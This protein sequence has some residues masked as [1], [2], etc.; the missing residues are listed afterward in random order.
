[1][2]KFLKWFSISI[3]ILLVLLIIAPFLFKG[4]IIS[5]IKEETNQNLNAKVD[6]SDVS[7]SLIRNFPNVSVGLEN[8][9]VINLQPFEGDTLVYAKKLNVVLDLMSVISGDQMIIRS[10]SLNDPVL[11]FLVNKDGIPNWDIAKKEAAPSESAQPSSF[12]ASLKKY[13]V[14][15]AKILYNDET[16]PFMLNLEGVDHSGSGDFT[17]DLFTLSTLSKVKRGDME[18]AGIRYISK[19]IAE[20]QADLEMDMKNLK[21]TFKQ[22]KVALNDLN[23]GVDGW[24]AMPDTNIDMDLKFAAAQSDF[25]NFISMVPA[26]YSE[27]FKDVKSSG[28]MALNGYIK[29]RYNAVSMPGFG[30]DLDI[31]NGMFKYPSLPA[32][33][34]NVFVNLKVD[35]PDGIPDHTFINLSRFHMEMNGDPFDAKLVLKTPVSD[36]DLDAFLKG[37]VDLSGIS[38]LVPLEKGTS[39]NGVIT[40][41]LTAKG[42]MSSIEKKQYNEF[43]AAGN[44]NLTGM[45]YASSEMKTPVNIQELSLSF[46][47]QCVALNAFNAKVGKSDF[48]ATGTIDNLLGFYLK[49]EMLKGAFNLNSGKIDLNEFMNGSGQAS[50]ASKD[51]AAMAVLDIPQNIDF[52]LNAMIGQLFYQNVIINNMKGELLVKDK[53]IRMKGVNMQLMDGSVTMDGSYSSANLKNPSFDFDMNIKDFD[54]QRTSLTFESVQKM[55][56]IIK[57]CSGKFSTTLSVKGLLDK[58]MSPAMNSLNGGGKLS[59]STVTVNNFPVFVKIADALKMNQ[60][61]NMT[62]PPVNPS[63]KFTDGRVY[64]DPFD[65][66]VNGIKSTVAGSNG[67]D[68]TIDYRINSQIPRS[69]FGGQA[70]AVLENMVSAANAKGANFSVGDVVPV[71]IKVG[72]TVN[73][74]KIGTDVNSAG[75]K[76]MDDL[77]AK[78]KEEL[79]KKKA[80]AEARAKAEADKLKAEAQAKLDAEKQRAAAEAERV[81]KEAE[82]RAKSVADS[83]KK[84]AE[85]AAKKN[86][87]NL[88]KK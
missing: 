6:F 35:N 46:N 68:Q 41:D 59:T 36:P 44:F 82:A 83:L 77:K 69:A 2:K 78:A 53:A 10:L 66:N 55:A 4:K 85:D 19:A 42:R 23:I 74:P 37:K 65:M 38:K 43:N 61:K 31:D 27:N 47:P 51:T 63:F 62:I 60:W 28:K 15:N 52:S 75:S 76:V 64:V 40:A 88:F 25:K 71:L 16:M 79:D 34:N 87:K 56:P 14:S 84:A 24:V 73:D 80:E 3:V 45:N 58:T 5:K 29:G 33:L 67:F 26:V 21:F 72:G 30:I 48:K 7:L 57:N 17:Q 18:Y 81:K 22:N 54:I 1:M 12:K 20:V 32:S 39:L 70:N 8:L 50:N 13:T 49:N 11:K 9:S 86:L